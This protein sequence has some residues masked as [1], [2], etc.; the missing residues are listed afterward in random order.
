MNISATSP[1]QTAEYLRTLPAIRERCDRVFELAKQ[2]KL[3]YFE[4]NPE[5][6]ADAALFCANIITVSMLLTALAG[7]SAP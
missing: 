7:L 6:E 5:K 1:Q 4:Y 3:E 2:S